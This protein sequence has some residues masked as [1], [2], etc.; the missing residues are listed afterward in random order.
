MSSSEPLHTPGEGDYGWGWRSGTQSSLYELG[1]ASWECVM[2]ADQGNSLC[3]FYF[4]EN[5]SLGRRELQL[6][7]KV[8]VKDV[9][10]LS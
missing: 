2:K 6:G 9:A 5:Q 7:V 4:Q 1:A 3:P 8:P 10:K